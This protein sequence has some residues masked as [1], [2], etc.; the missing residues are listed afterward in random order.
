MLRIELLI[1]SRLKQVVLTVASLTL[2]RFHRTFTTFCKDLTTFLQFYN[3]AFAMNM[4]FL[5]GLS[6]FLGRLTN[7][8]IERVAW[9]YLG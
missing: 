5:L 7:L 9:K 8:F 2:S 1:E 4:L 3:A 6:V